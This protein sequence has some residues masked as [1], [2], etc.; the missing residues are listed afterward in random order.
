MKI[1]HDVIGILHPTLLY[2]I[3]R[4]T[5][6]GK[7][8]FFFFKSQAYL[9]LFEISLSLWNSEDISNGH[10]LIFFETVTSVFCVSWL[11]SLNFHYPTWPPSASLS[12]CHLASGLMENFSDPL[13]IKF[14]GTVGSPSLAS[15]PG[16]LSLDCNPSLILSCLGLRDNLFSSSVC[17][18]LLFLSVS[19]KSS[20][21]KDQRGT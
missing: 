8:S 2:P 11:S 3:D 6:L 10:Y 20:D 7:I 16:I 14:N 17:S 9:S 15:L 19:A 12:S 21:N 13:L 18:F 4:S 1:P 5:P